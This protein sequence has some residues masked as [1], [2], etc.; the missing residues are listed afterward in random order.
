MKNKTKIFALI[1]FIFIAVLGITLSITHR[2]SENVI[3]KKDK[4]VSVEGEFGVWETTSYLT[5][6]SENIEID[7]NNI[8]YYK[9]SAALEDNEVELHF[10]TSV[11]ENTIDSIGA[12]T[13]A[14]YINTS[15][16]FFYD[17]TY[18]FFVLD[19]ENNRVLFNDEEGTLKGYIKFGSDLPFC[20]FDDVDYDIS[21]CAGDA[22]YY[23]YYNNYGLMIMNGKEITNLD[24]YSVD[25]KATYAL[26]SNFYLIRDEL[27]IY[28]AF[29]YMEYDNPFIDYDP[30]ISKVIEKVDNIDLSDVHTDEETVYTS[31]QS[32]WGVEGNSYDYYVIY[33]LVGTINYPYYWNFDLELD[34]SVGNVV[35]YSPNGVMYYRGNG[36]DF[37]NTGICNRST[38]GESDVGCYIVVGYNVGSQELNVTFG[39]NVAVDTDYESRS[40]SF[41]WNHTLQPTGGNVTP[42]YPS[43]LNKD[44]IQRSNTLNAG[45]GAINRLN[46]GSSVTFGWVI[47]STSSSI[48]NNYKAF[49]L[50][51]LTNEGNDSY[52][53][54]ISSDKTEIDNNYSN[55]V[56]PSVLGNGDYN[57][58]S[59]YPQDDVEYDYNLENNSYVLNVN[60]SYSSYGNKEVYV[61]INNG[62]YELIGTYVKTSEG[63]VYTASDSRTTSN[64]NVTESNPVVLPEGVTKIK[65][66]YTGTRAAVYMGIN[67]NV[68]VNGTDNV[69]SIINNMGD[70]VVLKDVAAVQVND[71][72]L[73]YNRLGSYLTR[74]EVKSY[75]SSDSV[76]NDRIDNGKTDSIT[77]EDKFYEQ[78]NYTDDNKD[79]ALSILQERKTGEIDELLP[80]GAE[81]DGDVTVKTIAGDTCTASSTLENNYDGSGRDLVKISVTSCSEE[82]YYDTG[83]AIQSGFVVTFNIT[84]GSL[85]NQVNGTTLKKD[86]M[87][88]ADGELGQGYSNPLDAPTSLFSDSNVRNKFANLVSNG[89]KNLLFVTTE[90]EVESLSIS[91]G[92]YSKNVRSGSDVNYSTDTSVVE[93]GKYTYKLQYAFTSELE[94][95]TNVVFVD[96]LENDYGSNEHFNGY[97]D[98]VDISYLDGLGVDATV[99]YAIGD[100]NVDIFD[101]TQWSTT[102]PDD[103]TTIKA[104]AVVCGSY[105]FKGSDRVSPTVYVDLIAPNSYSENIKAYN[106]S[107]I[108]YKNVGDTDL[109]SLTS[110]VTSVTL[111]KALITVDGTSN[112]GKGT[113]TNP[114]IID[115]M[116]SYEI[117]VV[118]TDPNNGFDNVVVEVQIPD[119]L[120]AV[121]P[122]S[123]N[124]VVTYTINHLD[125]G[126]TKKFNVYLEVSE[127]P[128]GDKVYTATYKL[129]SL[130]GLAYNGDE[131]HI[132]NKV[133]LPVIEAHKYAKTSDTNTFTDVAGMI[134]KKDEEFSYRVSIVNTSGK[135]ATNVT[136]VDTVPEGLTVVESTLGT[137]TYEGNTITWNVNV[138]ANST[139]NIDYK[140]KLNSDAT[141]G[142][143]YRSSAHV[144]LPNPLLTSDLLYD[145]DTNV[146]SV[147]YQIAS[148]FKVTN[149]LEGT[150]ADNN[151]EFEYEVTFN[152]SSVNA[153]NYD[154]FDTNNESLTALNLDQDGQGSY[155][156]K[157]KGNQSITFKN[158]TGG[159]EY[160]IK[161]KKYAGYTTSPVLRGDGDYATITGNTNEEGTKNY[162]FTNAYSATG[163]T[164]LTAKVTYDK[165]VAVD[166]FKVSV[167]GTEYDVDGNGNIDS[168][169]KQYNNEVG[170]YTYIIKQV[171]TG[172]N[173]ISYDSSEYKA[174][175]NVTD[176]KDGNLNTQLKYYDSNNNEVDEVVFNNT[177]LPN[178]L[179]ISNV[180]NS[181]YVDKDKIFTYE[182]T[183]TNGDGTYEVKDNKGNSLTNIEFVNGTATYTVNLLS[184]ES[185]LISDLPDGVDYVIKQ[186][187]VEYYE[188]TSNEES[189]TTDNAIIVTGTTIEG[190]KE[191]KFDNRYETSASFEPN[192]NVQLEGKEIE[193]KEFTFKLLD[194][195]E[196]ATNG[197]TVN[198]N[199]NVEGL[200]SFG[201]INYNRPGTYRYEIVQ[202]DN[203]SN[204]IYF[205]FSKVYLVLELTDNGDGTME[206][207]SSYEYENGQE[208]LANKYSEEPIVKEDEQEQGKEN[209]KTADRIRNIIVLMLIAITLFIVE[210]WVRQRRYKMNA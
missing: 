6:N 182:I 192:I 62:N 65:V 68:S 132:Y 79:E 203:G 173:K 36:E 152:G 144:T 146:I 66:S 33:P 88:V 115:G 109:K 58:V 31:W 61:S 52:T 130:N 166:M 168:I 112:Y 121:S 86:A 186:T 124:G 29:E 195:S 84:Y 1:S 98:N 105:V 37:E 50:W 128:T 103:V 207:L 97:L 201:E 96:K 45:D 118:N 53:V 148:S 202:L 183:L 110:E 120:T 113:A 22:V 73:E 93:S 5:S 127:P 123:T 19:D 150:L 74:L 171:N 71:E 177:Y 140:V 11:V 43:G 157:L 104:I 189:T 161:Q 200:V 8:T 57:I 2:K 162:E 20:N 188:T 16:L 38:N 3:N 82:N 141:L 163:S 91:V 81:L 14:Y 60:N 204:H 125:A 205:D 41:S 122:T 64:N 129:K 145:E 101:I 167:D 49:N 175:V 56:S 4:Y 172:I 32:E 12:G 142:T 107:N 35:A 135:N 165:G 164:S 156:F 44:I 131:G 151:K 25:L 138:N 208:F 10:T 30:I 77:Y 13:I 48:T 147:L 136:V 196:G 106:K 47:E 111:N 42:E 15:S 198:G 70:T 75:A 39:M 28:N 26:D 9:N 24:S 69:K 23:W 99:Y 155:T 210:R 133:D 90:T 59:F 119:G 206:V 55:V 209:P 137:G 181:E 193:D 158:L 40:L 94:E 170:Q 180:N 51:N 190:S 154:V 184:N 72:G 176:N 83:S 169:T 191:I 27:E 34:F 92:T 134:V 139:L 80:I 78:L 102:K 143:A 76:V 21:Q 17:D 194:V 54:S 108:I 187:L 67:I 153:G 85:A 46:N 100:V 89:N 197:Y 199:N 160:T 7:G 114:A 179:T 63:I 174:V 117:S 18:E 149:K 116:L 126:A 95:I 178:G 87:Y 185:I 159:V